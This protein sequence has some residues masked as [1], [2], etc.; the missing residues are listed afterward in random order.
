M[1]TEHEYFYTSLQL[2]NKY[3]MG[4]L[5]ESAN[6]RAS[7]YTYKVSLYNILLLVLLATCFRYCRERK[8]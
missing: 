6:I 3:D 4:K 1:K 8:S 7:N 5:L 2:F